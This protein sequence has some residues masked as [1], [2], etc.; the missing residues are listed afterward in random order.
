MNKRRSELIEDF[1]EDK[2]R[3]KSY[4]LNDSDTLNVFKNDMQ[5]I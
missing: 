4:H 5:S 1:E 3:G 2:T